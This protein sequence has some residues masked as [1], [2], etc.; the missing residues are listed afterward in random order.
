MRLEG[1]EGEKAKPV[2]LLGQNV[3]DERIIIII[4]KWRSLAAANVLEGIR[5]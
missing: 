4:Q 3:L 2:T 1:E 5:V